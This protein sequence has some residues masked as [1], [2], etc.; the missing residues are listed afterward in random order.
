MGTRR[1]TSSTSILFL[2][3]FIIFYHCASSLQ[4]VFYHLSHTKHTTSTLVIRVVRTLLI[5][6]SFP[7]TFALRDIQSGHNKPASKPQEGGATTSACPCSIYKDSGTSTPTS[8]GR[9]RSK[10][11]QN[12]SRGGTRRPSTKFSQPN[13]HFRPNYTAS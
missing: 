7:I 9:L 5:S 2:P 4:P 8:G 10:A 6:S 11:S 3:L 12:R 13:P 1:T